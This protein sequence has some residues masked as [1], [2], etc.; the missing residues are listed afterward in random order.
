MPETRIILYKDDAGSTPVLD[1]LETLEPEAR[2]RCIQKVKLLEQFGRELGQPHTEPL[3]DG[4]HDL[5]A[6]FNGDYYHML[7]F[8]HSDESIVIT[9]GFKQE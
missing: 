9:H 5:C 1:W 8:F 2:A 6:K 7:Y 3:Q 4:I